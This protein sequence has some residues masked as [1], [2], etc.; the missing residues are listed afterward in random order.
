MRKMRAMNTT[1]MK[2][3]VMDVSPAD[4]QCSCC[5]DSR[6]LTPPSGSPTQLSKHLEAVQARTYHK[7]DDKTMISAKPA[8]VFSSTMCNPLARSTGIFI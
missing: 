8:L 5:A 7:F 2:F 3:P 1:D 4:R 6:L